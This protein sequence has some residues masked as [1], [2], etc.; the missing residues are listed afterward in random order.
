MKRTIVTT[1]LLALCT[2]I[3]A[4]GKIAL[5]TQ[6]KAECVRSDYQSL[7][8]SFS[9]SSIESVE[10]NTE[11]GLFSTL[12]M[13]N[14][15][16]GGNLGEP[17]IPVVNELIAVPLGANPIIR[18]THY[19][20]TDYRLEDYGI[21][22]LN[23]RQ[24]SLRKDQKAEEV[25]FVYNEAAYQTRGLRQEP[26]AIVSVEGVMRGVQLGKMTIEPVSYD[27]VSNLLRVFND[28]EVEV[29]FENAD[30]KA[31]EDMLISTYSPYFDVVYQ[32]LFNGRA[33]LDAYD[34]HPDLYTTPVKM[35]VV[36]TS[37]YTGSTSFNSWLTWKKRKGIEVDVQTV[38]T[39]ASASTIRTLIQE[40]Y[41]ANHPTFLVIIG[42]RADVTN[43]TSYSISGGS[44]SPYVS[45]L[46][47]ASVDN[48]IFHDMY[49]SRMSVS[50]TSELNNLVTKIL[51]YEKCTVP[52]LSYLDDAVLIAGWDRTWTPKVGKPT[53]QYANNYYFNAAHGFDDVHVYLTTASGQ[54][55]ECYTWLSSGV[56]FLNY[57][58][59][60]SITGL[61]DPSFSNSNVSSLTNNNKYFWVMANCCLTGNWGASSTCLGETLIR[62][63]NKGAFGYIGSIPESYWYEDYYFGVGA[64]N[65]T[66]QM[67]TMNQTKTGVYDGMFM[68]NSW[69]TLNAVPFL[70][71]VAVTY[72]H[73]NGYTSDVSD[74]YYWRGY[75]CLGDGS[76][77]PYLVAPGTNTV[78]HN[79]VLSIG[80][81]SFEVSALPG[82][83]VAITVNDEIIGV[84]QVGSTG[85]VSVP[86]I[87]QNQP[88]TAMV[89]VTCPQRQ[90][91]IMNINIVGS[92]AQY[93]IMATASP[94]EGGTITGAGTYYE[95]ITCTLNATPNRGYQ[96]VNWT[97]GSNVVSTNPTYSFTVTGARTLTA[98]FDALT[99]RNITLA[100]VSYGT[101]TADMTAAYPGETVTLTASPNQGYVFSSWRV[102]KTGDVSTTIPVSNNSFEMPDFDVT[103]SAHFSA[104]TIG[105]ITIGS[106]TGTNA[107]IP[108][109]VYY[110]YSLS[111]Q[112]YTKDEM[113]EACTITAV[114]FY[115]NSSINSGARALD[116]YMSHTDNATLSSWSSVNADQKVFSGN[117]TFSSNGWKT[118]TLD[119]PF[120]YNGTSNL[121]LTVDDNTGSHNYYGTQNFLTYS[122]NANRAIFYYSGSNN[123]SPANPSTNGNI[124]KKNNQVKFTTRIES[125][126]SQSQALSP[127]WNWVS[128]YVEL[129]GAT[130]LAELEQALTGEGTTIV[131][132]GDGFVVLNNNH[133][134]GS[135][136]TIQNEQMYQINNLGNE[137]LSL[138][139]FMAQP[140]NHPITIHPGW[141]W[142]GY[143]V[144]EDLPIEIALANYQPQPNDII[145]SRDK[146][147]TYIEG[148]GWWGTLTTL[149][150]GEGYM[151]RSMAETP[152]TLVFQTQR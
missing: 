77:M 57:T 69:N 61:A 64:T 121:L 86:I 145:K 67:P 55:Q 25:P 70:G 11:R 43:C 111:Q 87:Q 65:V 133:W 116:I 4:Q 135:L 15:V 56:G 60:G 58:A 146:F 103:V 83:Y 110:N 22:K 141:N 101:I 72:A 130:S 54:N 90:P 21:Q 104:E 66:N 113:G 122:T 80:A 117:V 59:H 12:T 76:V 73:A 96:F 45:D 124:M 34:D 107:N 1:L 14:T 20:T 129:D 115:Y 8:A 47:Y 100:N 74:E 144:N 127:G 32:Q 38:A 5:R 31:T 102:Y 30:A 89:V 3:F 37:K 105:E 82:S 143:P 126:V 119:T 17:Q 151:Y 114:S 27:P 41:N 81:T 51:A 10:T 63:A 84:A 71:N 106:G 108:T 13:P 49:M 93:A 137:S 123:Q 16:I 75:T 40:R 52:D 79:N 139:G 128:F 112:I 7:K 35:L 91:Y 6:D 132:Q 23:P 26:K 138:S 62:A 19:S 78:S 42:D 152:S 88:G 50:S 2:T 136:T 149:C 46:P 134:A 118:I 150:A 36:T 94:I 148:Y 120:T 39:S 33:V 68:E 99:L 24:P 9:F 92:G 28:I 18:I 125:N 147:S 131:S 109:N 48:D 85:T 98:N 140:G 142:I 44:A 95:Q 53:I 29:L 97:E